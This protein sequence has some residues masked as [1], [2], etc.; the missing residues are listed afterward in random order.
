MAAGRWRRFYRPLLHASLR[1]PVWVAAAAAALFTVALLIFPRLGAEFIPQL[2]E[3]SISIQMVRG[4]SVGIQTSLDLQC[5]AEQ[6]LLREF[7]EIR[8]IFSRL[9]TAEIATDPMGPNVA[10]TY[11][12][13]HPPATWRRSNGRQATKHDLIAAMRQTL[14]DNIPGQVVLFTQPIQLRFNEILAGARADIAVKIHGA[15]F[16]EL[17]HIAFAARDVLRT[18]PGGGDVEFD[19]IGRIPMLEIVPRRAVMRRLNVHP[20]EISRATHSA[21]AGARVGHIVEDNRSFPVIVRLAETLRHNRAAIGDLPVRTG[22]GGIVGLARVAEL[23]VQDRVGNITREMMGRRATILVNLRG[24]D[25]QGFVA[26]ATKRLA[27]EID[28]PPGYGMEFGGQF[29]NLQRARERLT[30]VVPLA[31][32]L[33]FLLI[34]LSVGNLRQALMVFSAVPLAITG[35]IF[36]LWWRGIPFSISA[37]VGFVALS[38]IAVLDALVLVNCFN[39][40]RRQGAAIR[41]AVIG[42][43]MLRLRPVLMT[44]LVASLGFVPMA[45]ATTTGAEVQRPLATVVIGGIISSTILTLLVLPGLYHWIE[46]RAEKAREQCSGCPF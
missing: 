13:L 5:R 27:D 1:F 45:L 32:C 42:G 12:L 16:A 4:N 18:I 14:E 17:E 23:Q 37:G 33:I 34:Y 39:D 21:L 46:Q 41:D 40:L 30:V 31:L 22:D 29:E 28:L 24:R 6:L 7:P 10:D 8:H 9:G 35:G 26:E 36:F 15:D 38:G 43:A 3:G 25:V 11:V 20:D 2:D 44:S 19:A